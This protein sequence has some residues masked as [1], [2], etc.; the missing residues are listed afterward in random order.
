MKWQQIQETVKDVIAEI[1]ECHVY[2]EPITSQ[3]Q[4]FPRAL[5]SVTNVSKIGWDETRQRYDPYDQAIR[6]RQYGVRLIRVQVKVESRDQNLVSGAYT[7][8]DNIRTRI[9]RPS[10]LETLRQEDLLTT[11][12]DLGPSLAVSSL[13]DV[14][15]IDRKD[16]KG[17]MVSYAAFDII[18]QTNVSDE[19]AD[20]DYGYI[21]TVEIEQDFGGVPPTEI[22]IYEV[23]VHTLDEFPIVTQDDDPLVTQD[24]DPI[25]ADPA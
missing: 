18:F 19:Q 22:K 15:T 1:G 8:A 5:L 21:K 3:W 14:R 10:V 2:W 20:F 4:N 24:D 12:D 7:V 25:V 13:T 11:G 6:L 16:D 23:G 17:R 9:Y